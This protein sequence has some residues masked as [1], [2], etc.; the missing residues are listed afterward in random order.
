MENEE[1]EEKKKVCSV[2]GFD[3]RF[4]LRFVCMRK[5]GGSERG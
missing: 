5:G 1:W 4:A 2:L 3:L